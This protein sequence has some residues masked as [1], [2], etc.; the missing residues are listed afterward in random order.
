MTIFTQNEPLTE[1]EFDYLE[2]FLE[3]CEGGTAM[4]IE[5]LDGFFSALV[6][7]PDIVMPSE[8]LPE[9]FGGETSDS[10]EFDSLEEANEILALMMRH[11]NTIAA[12]LSKDEVYL[13]ILLEDEDGVAYGNDWA[14]GFIRGTNMRHDGWARLLGDDDHGGC[15]I[16]MLMLYHE[17]DEDPTL[18]PKPIGLEQREEIIQ[19][20][21]AGLLGAHR[22]FRQHRQP[23][24]STRA[25]QS[26]HAN[27]KIGRND[28]C[29]CGSGKKY[30]R[31]CG[32]ATIN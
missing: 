27:T 26:R 20:M 18:R 31:C 9:V 29:P 25:P 32:G 5:Q 7:G 21:A 30:K 6:A 17:H 3:S 28:P 12:T 10:H 23:Y 8:Y 1:A 24:A 13:P 4:N 19:H 2:E 15:M 11:W 16:P 22:Y 14:R